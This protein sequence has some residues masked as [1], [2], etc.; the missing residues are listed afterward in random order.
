MDNM[1]GETGGSGAY[2]AFY[3]EHVRDGTQT[4]TTGNLFSIGNT[5]R[6]NACSDSDLAAVVGWQSYDL[7]SNNS[8]YVTDR[9]SGVCLSIIENNQFTGLSG[10]VCLS[11]PA[12]FSLIRN[13]DIAGEDCEYFN[14]SKLYAPLCISSEVK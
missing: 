1:F 9:D 4:T 5:F 10:P 2:N 13:N 12:N 14:E 11:P 3:N 7:N 6:N 8:S